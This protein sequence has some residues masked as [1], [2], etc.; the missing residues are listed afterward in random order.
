MERTFQFANMF[1]QG[2]FN[3]SWIV[4]LITVMTLQLTVF[5][6]GEFV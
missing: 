5:N 6:R 1:I 3:P 2:G 4:V